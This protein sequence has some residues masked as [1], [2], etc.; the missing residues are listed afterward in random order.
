MVGVR[1]IPIDGDA[2]AIF[3]RSRN[4]QPL[5]LLKP[6]AAFSRGT[7]AKF[8]ITCRVRGD[9][10]HPGKIDLL[11]PPGGTGWC[12]F[13]SCGAS[14]RSGDQKLSAETK[15]RTMKPVCRLRSDALGERRGLQPHGRAI[16][17]PATARPW[18]KIAAFP[19]I[20][21]RPETRVLTSARWWTSVQAGAKSLLHKR[22][23]LLV[24][25]GVCA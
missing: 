24:F 12:F 17:L 15:I 20:C 25:S 8:F 2:G 21:R 6:A 4:D 14:R 16:R 19:S 11:P 22:R 9:H 10:H 23:T 7:N 18:A 3:H 5:L 13:V 1:L